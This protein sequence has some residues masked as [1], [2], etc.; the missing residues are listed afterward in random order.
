MLCIKNI[1]VFLCSVSGN[2]LNGLR[3][4]PLVIEPIV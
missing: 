4:I 1:E 3:P 2:S